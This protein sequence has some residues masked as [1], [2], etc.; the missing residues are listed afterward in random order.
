MPPRA[1]RAGQRAELHVIDVVTGED[2]LVHESSSLLFEAPNWSPDGRWL[3]V[4]GGGRLFR[5]PADGGE[6]E[7]V[8]LGDVPDI[9]NDHVLSPDGAT[10]YVSAED[11]HLYAVPFEGGGAPRR[12]SNDRGAFHHYLHGI[13]PDGATL[14]YIGLVPHADGT[15]TTNVWTIPTAGGLDVQLTD[16]EFPD[17]GA[18]FSPDGRWVLF[19]SERARTQPGHAQLFRMRTDGSSVE[20]LTFDERVNWFPHVSPDGSRLAYISFPPG[21][22]GHPAD[23]DVVLR[24]LEPYDADGAPG[25]VRDLVVLFGGQGTINVP[26]WASDSRRL[27]YV[28]YPMS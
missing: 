15:A 4:N 3:V 20:Q 25:T 26:S 5:L 12:V 19:N 24:L 17:D 23:L 7:E 11:G 10:V 21:T 22:L 8:P 28:A 13:S 14:A 18:E 6:L 1:L 16:D 27:A 2:R 9:N